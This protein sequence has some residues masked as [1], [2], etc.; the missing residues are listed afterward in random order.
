[1]SQI[2]KENANSKVR[3]KQEATGRLEKERRL[4]NNQKLYDAN[5]ISK[6]M[7]DKTRD[8]ILRL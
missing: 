2:K 1:M 5:L 6:A 3:V 4:L 7:F 8:I